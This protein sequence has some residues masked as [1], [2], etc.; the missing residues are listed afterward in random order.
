MAGLRHTYK[1][2]SEKADLICKL[3]SEGYPLIKICA[4]D[5]MPSV[6]TVMSWLWHDS[7]HTRKNF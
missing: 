7:P 5:G 4:R 1:A 6:P 2:A 3:L